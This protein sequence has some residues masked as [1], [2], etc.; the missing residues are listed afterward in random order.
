MNLLNILRYIKGY[1]HFTAEGGFPER[2]INLCAAK[3]IHIWHL[4]PDIK[5]LSGCVST[6]SFFRLRAVARKSGV[7]LYIKS[8]CGLPFF[9]KRH[10]SRAILFVGIF[11]YIFTVALMNSFIWFIDVEGTDTVSHT[12]I[13]NTLEGYGLKTGAYAKGIDTELINREGVN[14]FEGRLMWMSVNIKGSKAVIEVRDYIDEHEDTTY[15]DPCNIVA[16]FDGTVLSAEVFNGDRVIR[17]G[18]AVKKGDLLISGVV[19][20]TDSSASYL[21]ARGRITAL[22][23]VSKEKSYKLDESSY[24]RLISNK[25]SYAP[26]LLWLSF[27]DT[28]NKFCYK[29][30]LTVNGTVLP[31]GLST[32][33]EK[34]YTDSEGCDYSFLKALDSYTAEWYREFAN[35]NILSSDTRL[36]VNGNKLTI[37]S[38]ISC[39]DFMGVKSPIYVD[40]E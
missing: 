31:F 25:K 1:V 13:I 27:P 28:E 11:F 30:H 9:V 38:E 2:F 33:A 10:K 34:E 29:E 7:R 8:K 17:A 19:E 26:Q 16:D 12:Q 40:T 14:R 32:T 4:E 22:H 39:I 5:R 37:S 36:T 35:T 6:K 20:N 24:K 3:N 23:S 18:N 21:E 15:K